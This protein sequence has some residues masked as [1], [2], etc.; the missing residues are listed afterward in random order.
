MPHPCDQCLQV[1]STGSHSAARTFPPFL[2]RGADRLL[3]L[4]LP[5]LPPPPLLQ[6]PPPPLLPTVSRP[7]RTA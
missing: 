7:C 5:L 6:L 3:P 2:G 1:E 4:P